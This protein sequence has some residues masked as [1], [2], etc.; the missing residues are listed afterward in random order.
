MMQ[1][2]VRRGLCLLWAAAL[3]LGLAACGEPE[4]EVTPESEFTVYEGEV[5]E[6]MNGYE[7]T[8]IDFWDI[9][10]N[11]DKAGT[12]YNDAW[13]KVL[14]EV[15]GLYNCTITPTYA[16]AGEIFSRVQPEVAAGE[17]AYDLICTTQ[18]GIGYFI[19][20]GY[21]MDLNT[22]EVD[23]SQPYWNQ[24]IRAGT[25]VGGKTYAGGGPFIFD[26]QS[27]WMLYY[28]AT[29]WEELGLP[30][31]YQLVRDGKWTID[32]FTEYATRAKLDMDGDGVVNS[33]DDRWGLITAEGD[34]IRSMVL[35]MEGHYFSTDENGRVVLACNNAHT[36]EIVEKLQ[37]MMT[38]SGSFL[39]DPSMVETDR[40]ER[41]VSGHS[42][43]YAYMPGMGQLKDMEDDWGALPLPKFDE[44]QEEYLTGID[45]NAFVFGA[46]STNQNTHELS[47]ILTA[48]GLHAQILEE[49]Y[50]PDYK[51]TYWRHEEQD[52]AMMRDYVVGRGQYDM[53]LMMRNCVPAF[54]APVTRMENAILTRGGDFSSTIQSIE[55]AV[56]QNLDQYF[57]Q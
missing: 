57:K 23:W 39:L 18:W 56:Q 49:I 47:T 53:A 37:N 27:T 28:N 10:W 45:Q 3:L 4:K 41:F 12:P 29:I 22:L 13:I 17:K 51:E 21:L 26:S 43:F 8:V 15:E 5:P 32:L 55:K 9:H 19:G 54:W 20:G 42:L 38:I 48:L 40:V 46:T 16:G 1:K 35:G 25:S 2:I 36:F 7:F 14:D 44:A 50:W 31:P 34:F 24:N 52:T 6:D 11:R 30:D 33:H